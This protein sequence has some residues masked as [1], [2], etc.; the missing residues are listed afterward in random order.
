M[1]SG[2]GHRW[3]ACHQVIFLLFAVFL[4][5]VLQTAGVL[6]TFGYVDFFI[7][8]T[9]KLEPHSY[10]KKFLIQVKKTTMEM[11]SLLPSLKMFPHLNS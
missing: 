8:N 4:Y 3:T 7:I 5:K 9:L 6:A 11:N 2:V 10:F 1:L